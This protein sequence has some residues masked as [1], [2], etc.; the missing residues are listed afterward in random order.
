L[1]FICSEEFRN[2]TF[3]PISAA[4]NEV[5]H[6][7]AVFLLKLSQTSPV[8][9]VHGL[10][11]T[12]AVLNFNIFLCETDLKPLDFGTIFGTDF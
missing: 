11:V 2:L 8:T 1:G 12:L 7:E 9:E 3:L 5:V 10:Q 4:V 6:D